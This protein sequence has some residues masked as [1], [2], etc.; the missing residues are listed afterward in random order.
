M[1]HNCLL[2]EYNIPGDCKHP[3]NTSLQFFNRK[4]TEP[5]PYFKKKEA[6]L[7]KEEAESNK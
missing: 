6:L 2:C 4:G 5:C 1:M 3:K 7:K